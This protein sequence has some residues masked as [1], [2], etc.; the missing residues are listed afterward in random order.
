[1]LKLDLPVWIL[2]LVGLGGA[3][4][5]V[6]TNGVAIQ[7]T[8]GCSTVRDALLVDGTATIDVAKSDIGKFGSEVGVD[9]KQEGVFLSL[10]SGS[11]V[12]VPVI[13]Y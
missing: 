8:L 9:W 10:S 11:V 13:T 1:M 4:P 12:R 3:S 5:V 7:G 6:D 2:L